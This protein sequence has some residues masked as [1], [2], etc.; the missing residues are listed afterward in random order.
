MYVEFGR[1]PPPCVRFLEHNP[2][3]QAR[4][5]FESGMAGSKHIEELYYDYV[6]FLRGAGASREHIDAAYDEWRRKFPLSKQPD[7]RMT[8]DVSPSTND[9]EYAR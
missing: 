7:P 9:E 3:D 6:S 4:Q 2:A 8:E 1:I 5:H